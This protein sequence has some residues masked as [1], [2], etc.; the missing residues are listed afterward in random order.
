[1]QL[2]QSKLIYNLES[3]QNNGGFIQSN[4]IFPRPNP[5]AQTQTQIQNNNDTHKMMPGFQNKLIAKE[6]VFTQIRNFLDSLGI[7]SDVLEFLLRMG[8]S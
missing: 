4:N 3:Q 8:L 7:T 5:L 1:M 2:D 6:I